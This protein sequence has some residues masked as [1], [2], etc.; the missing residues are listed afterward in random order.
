MR[1]FQHVQRLLYYQC[2]CIGYA[3]D[4]ST[5]VPGI[6]NK[7]NQLF[8]GFVFAQ[9]VFL[10]ISNCVNWG[11]DQVALIGCSSRGLR[12][13][14]FIGAYVVFSVVLIMPGKHGPRGGVR[15][16]DNSVLESMA[17]SPD[18]THVGLDSLSDLSSETGVDS[19]RPCPHTKRSRSPNWFID[20]DANV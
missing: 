8:T 13:N 6:Y 2:N 15:Q 20:S 16:L 19:S 9:C 4:L 10:W 5:C 3:V 18:G 1:P 12:V 14:P 7:F 11:V 17:G